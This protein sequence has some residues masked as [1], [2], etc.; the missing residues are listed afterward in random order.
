MFRQAVIL[1]IV[2]AVVCNGLRRIP[3]KKFPS[4]RKQLHEVGTSV[5]GLIHRYQQFSNVYGPWP[6]PLSNYLDAQYYG[7]ISIGTPPQKFK[8]VFDT[9]S[10]NLWVP[11][12][13]CSLTNIACLLHS[14]YDSSASSTYVKNGT[15]FA[16]EYGSGSLSGFLS[17]DMVTVAGLKV[18]SQT[19]AEAVKEPGVAFVAAHFDG[20]LGMGYP[21]ISVN[22]VTPVFQSMVAQKLVDAP[23]FSFYLNR[24]AT[25]DVGGE[26]ILGGS[27]PQYYKGNFSYV[28]V[29][30]QGYWQFKMDGLWINGKM[31][32]DLCVGGCQAIADTGTSLLA[33]P[34][35][36]ITKLNDFIGATPLAAGEYTVDCNKVSSLPSIG[37]VLGGK[38]FT[39]QG[40]D[41]ILQVT[42]PAHITF[43]AILQISPPM[44]SCSFDD[45]YV[46]IGM[47]NQ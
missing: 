42:H 29:S 28:P 19:F 16:I 6:E 46:S 11:S 33:G 10:S 25:A 13:Q 21:S 26:L 40:S 44:L 15:A 36:E 9:G 3:L 30:K 37:F 47:T 24:D 20:I 32:P 22:H 4:A 1:L 41:Y 43:N 8:V 34:T 23:V 17:T 45:H 18:K 35:A 12:K 38:Q 5:Q 14:K 39:L 31:S 7:E 2:T 27:D